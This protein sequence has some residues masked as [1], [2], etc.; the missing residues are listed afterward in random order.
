MINFF[1]LLFYDLNNPKGGKCLKTECRNWSFLVFQLWTWLWANQNWAEFGHYPSLAF[2][3]MG[4]KYWVFFSFR[5]FWDR[6]HFMTFKPNQTFQY[7]LLPIKPV[8]PNHRSTLGS[9]SM[10][11]LQTSFKAHSVLT[12]I[13][14]LIQ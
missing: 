3:S 12:P 10:H 8:Y 13:L 6:T 4:L 7:K 9:Y 5:L 11:R 2:Q 1:K 14:F